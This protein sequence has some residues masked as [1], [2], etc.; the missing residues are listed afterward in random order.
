M[1]TVAPQRK[2]LDHD[3]ASV[4][5]M[6]VE[7]VVYGVVYRFEGEGRQGRSEICCCA[8]QATVRSGASYIGLGIGPRMPGVF[9]DFFSTL[10]VFP[11][12][13]LLV[14]VGDFCF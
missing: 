4:V 9:G 11:Q 14:Y 12:T 13:V 1:V 8:T 5:V 6:S 2:L 7:D 10:P 3:L